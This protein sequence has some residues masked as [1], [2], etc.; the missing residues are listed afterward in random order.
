MSSA[1]KNDFFL[2]STMN[3]EKITK[4]RERGRRRQK[5][6]SDNE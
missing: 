2:I 5:N 6:C 4:C 1:K 3:D